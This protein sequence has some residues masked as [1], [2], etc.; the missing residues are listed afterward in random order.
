[1]TRNEGGPDGLL[2]VDKP[3]GPT[4]HD[5]VRWVR[6][7][8]RTRRVGHAGTLDPFA[9][10]LLACG[11]GRATRLL[12]FFAESEKTYEGIIRLGFATDT[13]DCT[14]AALGDP[15][16][17]ADESS[18]A[19]D[20]VAARLTGDLRQVPPMYSAKKIAGVP[21]HRL[22]RRGEIVDREAVAVRVRDWS[23]EAI[24]ATSLRFRVTCSA[25]TY[26]RVL[27]EDLGDL[28]GCGAHLS[29]LRRTRS[30]ALGVEHAVPAAELEERAAEALIPLDAVPLP[31]PSLTCSTE[32]AERA[33]RHG[34]ASPLASWE[35]S[36]AAQAACRTPSGELLGVA[37]VIDGEIRPD[38]VLAASD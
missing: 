10:G 16:E 8:L 7:A 35:G 34:G 5:V 26:V 9:T 32:Q 24:D 14:G 15:V 21:L 27:A 20:V 31:L 18:R 12:R 1:M 38:V 36:A 33:F 17:C 29:A 11:V 4:S 28:L 22:A 30:G 2:L 3:A 23:I 13:G 19:A 37:D 6:K 25:G